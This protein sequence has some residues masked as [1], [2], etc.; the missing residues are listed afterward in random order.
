[1]GLD[2]VS[3]WCLEFA[4][5]LASICSP[6]IW[7]AESAILEALIWKPKFILER[8]NQ[9]FRQIRVHPQETFFD[10]FH[11]WHLSRRSHC[12]INCN[13]ILLQCNPSPVILKDS[14]SLHLQQI[15]WKKIPKKNITLTKGIWE[16]I[17]LWPRAIL[18][19]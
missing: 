12:N 14:K 19:H 8:L 5:W 9:R 10:D 18:Y 11:S 13:N 6:L 1:M 15:F 16:S 2:N 7:L 4:L 3:N 17:N